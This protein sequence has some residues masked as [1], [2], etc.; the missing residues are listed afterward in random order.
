MDCLETVKEEMRKKDIKNVYLLFCQNVDPLKIIKL[1][2]KIRE[3]E[4]IESL[5]EFKKEKPISDQ[6]VSN[7]IKY[8][9]NY[10]YIK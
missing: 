2:Y 5:E 9:K 10:N 8:M 4:I 3:H 1:D 7:F 6:Q